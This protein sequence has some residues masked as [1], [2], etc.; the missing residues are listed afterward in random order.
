MQTNPIKLSKP[1]KM[2]VTRMQDSFQNSNYNVSETKGVIKNYV[3][4]EQRRYI[5]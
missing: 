5:A 4:T 2:T 3:Y 1:V